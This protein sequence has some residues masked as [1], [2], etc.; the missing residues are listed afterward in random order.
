MIDLAPFDA[1]T[2]GIERTSSL[3]LGLISGLGFAVLLALGLA[4]ASTWLSPG[5]PVSWPVLVFASSVSGILF[6][7]RVPRSLKRKLL[8][9]TEC[10]YFGRPPYDTTPP[11]ARFDHRLPATLRVGRIGVGGVLYLAPS[12]AT[13]VPHRVNLPQHRAPVIVSNG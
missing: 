11:D 4:L 5:K 2:E 3:R 1:Y 10:V 13:F 7:V 9:T 6:G 8:H 12:L